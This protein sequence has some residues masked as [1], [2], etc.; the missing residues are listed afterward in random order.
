MMSL[1][2]EKHSANNVMKCQANMPLLARIVLV[3][4]NFKYSDC[5][6]KIRKKLNYSIF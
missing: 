5:N 4:I 6:N 2:H 1:N 3:M